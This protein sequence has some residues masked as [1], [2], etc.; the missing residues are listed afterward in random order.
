M[1]NIHII[2]FKPSDW[3]HHSTHALPLTL[4]EIIALKGSEI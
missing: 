4:N 1:T 2:D 3:H